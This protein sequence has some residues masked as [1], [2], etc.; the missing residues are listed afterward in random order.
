[1][2]EAVPVSC[3]GPSAY[4]GTFSGLLGENESDHFESVSENR[5]GPVSLGLFAWIWDWEWI[6]DWGL[7]L[8]LAMILTSMDDLAMS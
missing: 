4:I 3:I 2:V 5:T 7:G 1:M 8:G 6:W